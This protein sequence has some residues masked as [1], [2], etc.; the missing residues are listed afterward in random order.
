MPV[1]G[2]AA[3]FGDGSPAAI[4]PAS[5]KLF[6]GLIWL[7]CFTGKLNAYELSGQGIELAP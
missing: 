1:S 4:E 3:K 5:T 6:G 2:I 7:F